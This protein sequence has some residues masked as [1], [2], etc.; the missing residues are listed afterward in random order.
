MMFGFACT[1]TK[2]LMPAPIAYAHNLHTRRSPP[3][4]RAASSPGCARTARARSPWNTVADG[5][6]ARIDTVVVSTQHADSHRHR[7]SAQ[8]RSSRRVIEPEPPSASARREYE[9][10][11][12]TRPAASSSAARPATPA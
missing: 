10:L 1:Q 3:R 2:E 4:A 6:P 8:G 12:R 11:R 7:G 9:V 5:L